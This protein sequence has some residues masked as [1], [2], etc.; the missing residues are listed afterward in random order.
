MPPKV[1]GPRERGVKWFTITCSTEGPSSENL[2][3]K[4]Q[5]ISQ[6]HDVYVVWKQPSETEYAIIRIQGMGAAIQLRSNKYTQVWSQ[7]S[8][9]WVIYIMIIIHNRSLDYKRHNIGSC[10]PSRPKTKYKF[11][12]VNMCAKV[13]HAGTLSDYHPMMKA[14]NRREK[15]HQ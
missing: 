15:N 4:I 8:N 1:W 3:R 2:R 7:P 6:V 11:E 10:S 9:Q 13:E 14:V 12:H 5:L